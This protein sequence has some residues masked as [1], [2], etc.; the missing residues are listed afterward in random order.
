M[1]FLRCIAL[2]AVAVGTAAFTAQAKIE[3]TI[4][5]TFTV[6][7]PGTLHVATQGGAIRVTPSHDGVVRVTAREKIDASSDAAADALLKDLTLT[8]EQSGNDIT[9]S[10]RYE[11]QLGGFFRRGPWPPVQ[12]AFD[13][14]VPASFAG[15]LRTSGGSVTVGDLDGAL[16]ARTSGGG[17]T[18]GKMGSTVEARTS[19][20][21]VSLVE[22]RG[23]VVVRTSGGSI[24]VGRVGGSAD[25]STSGGSIKID[26]V[27]GKVDAHTSGGSINATIVGPLKQDCAL[28]TSGGSVRVT[29]DK[30]AA[31]RLDAATSSGSVRAEGLAIA[32]ENVERN[33]SHLAGT[34]NGGGP[35]LRLRTSGGGIS[36]QT[37]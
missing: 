17:I 37:R 33:R 10:A 15:D 30:V 25:L 3:R 2:T 20:G 31:F 4:E 29:V 13:V 34:V 28:G 11:R 14:S 24:T 35:L 22:A 6:A 21:H 16:S 18:L 5:K 36:V 7:N 8:I 12:V 23:D 19:G 1:N 27:E 9:A 26:G 32:V